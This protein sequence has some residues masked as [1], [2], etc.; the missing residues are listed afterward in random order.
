LAQSDLKQ[1]YGRGSLRLSGKQHGEVRVFVPWILMAVLGV[2]L[3]IFAALTTEP[4]D[5]HLRTGIGG[6]GLLLLIASVYS[7]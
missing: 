5:V 6:F 7:I 4:E 1:G 3:M 2:G